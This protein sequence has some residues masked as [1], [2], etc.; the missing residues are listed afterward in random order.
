M[1][2]SLLSDVLSFIYLGLSFICLG[3][4]W[5]HHHHIVHACRR[6]TG[7]VLWPNLHLLFW[8]SLL[9]FAIGWTAENHFEPLP[10]FFYGCILLAAAF[11]DLLLQQLIIAAEGPISILRQAIGTCWPLAWPW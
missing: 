9:P 10:S 4:D 7:A 1:L 6:V 8:L 3:I 5:N 2:P 11:A